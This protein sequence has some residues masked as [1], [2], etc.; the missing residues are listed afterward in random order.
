MRLLLLG[1]L[2]AS[3]SAVGCASTPPPVAPPKPAE[4]NPPSS[5]D[6]VGDGA[7]QP[8]DRRE[9]WHEGTAT[10]FEIASTGVLE[11]VAKGEQ[12][13]VDAEYKY[14]AT[15]RCSGSGRWKM[16][17]QSLVSKNGRQFDVLSCQC[18][19]GGERREFTFDITQYFGK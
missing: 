1:L 16:M 5:G 11:V 12:D 19:A 4:L 6:A 3:A 17:E 7:G 10:V 13:G 8:S 15:L 2:A 14:L 18:S 9:V